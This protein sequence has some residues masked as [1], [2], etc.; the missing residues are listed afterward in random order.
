M[1]AFSWHSFEPIALI[2]QIKSIRKVVAWIVRGGGGEG[3]TSF[4]VALFEHVAAYYLV[5]A[6]EDSTLERRF[7]SGEVYTCSGLGE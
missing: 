7:D 5:C 4:I 3:C 2:G 6:Q 1:K